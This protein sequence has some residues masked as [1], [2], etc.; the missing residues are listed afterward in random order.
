MYTLCV[1]MYLMQTYD[2]SCPVNDSEGDVI[3]C[4]LAEGE[5]ECGNI[6]NL[7]PGNMTP[8]VCQLS[9]AS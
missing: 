2:L 9:K 4:R 7:F 8:E 5:E 6:C 3:R 1:K